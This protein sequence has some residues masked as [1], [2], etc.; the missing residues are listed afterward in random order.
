MDEGMK[1]RGSSSCAKGKTKEEESIGVVVVLGREKH[2]D[3]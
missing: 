1:N 2:K 3:H